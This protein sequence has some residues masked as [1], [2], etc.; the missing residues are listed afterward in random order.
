MHAS[1]F[2]SKNKKH[3]HPKIKGRR[4]S[5]SAVPPKF[6]QSAGSF[7]SVTGEARSVLPESSKV[8]GLP[9]LLCPF[10]AVEEH[11]CAAV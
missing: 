8:K 10:S 1:V 6:P 11:L 9:H 7:F 4:H 3:P 5:A 2:I